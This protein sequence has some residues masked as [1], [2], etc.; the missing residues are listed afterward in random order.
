MVRY[1]YGL[2]TPRNALQHRTE[3]LGS[4][5]NSPTGW[6]PW[7]R[8][9]P[10]QQLCLG[11]ILCQD[12]NQAQNCEPDCESDACC[13][14]HFD[15][16][17]SSRPNY[18]TL[19]QQVVAS[20]TACADFMPTTLSYWYLSSDDVL[21]RTTIMLAR[22]AAPPD[23]NLAHASEKGKDLPLLLPYT[24]KGAPGVN[25]CQE[26][27][28]TAGIFEVDYNQADSHQQELCFKAS[29]AFL[30]CQ[31]VPG[32]ETTFKV[33]HGFHQN[34]TNI[35]RTDCVQAADTF[36]EF[37]NSEF[38]PWTSP[39]SPRWYLQQC[40]SYQHLAVFLCPVAR[41]TC[42]LKLLLCLLQI[43]WP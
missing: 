42:L 20:F 30:K 39:I 35:S 34:D 33:L 43:F 21:I 27:W 15:I 41:Q 13:C 19:Q 37:L 40:L 9:Q 1:G 11:K 25:I 36:L 18:I 3:A 8:L 17:S 32:C 31:P 26:E 22:F 24:Q 16:T 5:R 23:I 2:W 4:H 38:G 10:Q 12:R 28:D 6:A 7:S 29:C 14:Q